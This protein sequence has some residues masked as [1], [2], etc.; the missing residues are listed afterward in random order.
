MN[1]WYVI[2][3][4][5]SSGKTTVLNIL[6]QRGYLTIDEVARTY[7]DCEL[8]KGKTI[9]Q[10]RKDE[11][12][13]QTSV[14]K[15]KYM[16][17]SH[18][19]TTR[20]TFFDRGIPDTHAYREL[21]GMHDH[22]DISKYMKKCF[23]KKIFLFEILSYK[24]DYARTETS[25]QAIKIEHLLEKQYLNNG[26]TVIKIPKLSVDERLKIIYKELCN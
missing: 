23:Y 25:D 26:F 17:E 4:A 3:G 24:Q 8:S 2:T 1:N 18:L 6:R 20:L 7:I 5:P 15:Q 9:E 11:L 16:I 12:A 13:F 21:Y 22:S 19:S 14:L 10:I